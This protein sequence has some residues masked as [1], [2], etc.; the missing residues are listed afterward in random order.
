MKK[1]PFP[2]RMGTGLS[3]TTLRPLL[4]PVVLRLVGAV[5]RNA[6]VISLLRGQLVQLHTDL[7][8]VQACNL[9]VQVFR[10]RVH[11]VVVAVGI[12]PQLKLG[13]DLVRE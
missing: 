11:L 1:A 8:K 7:G 13:Q 10:E 2:C 6:D 9:L 5:R 4:V 3:E 12:V